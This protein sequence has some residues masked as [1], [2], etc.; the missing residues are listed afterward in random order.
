M[1]KV[2][3]RLFPLRKGS[4][5]LLCNQ[6][7]RLELVWVVCLSANR[8]LPTHRFNHTTLYIFAL[9]TRG[10]DITGVFIETTRASPQYYYT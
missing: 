10:Y 4:P 5:L 9:N 6:T 7:L 8:L 2:S 3:P 1:I